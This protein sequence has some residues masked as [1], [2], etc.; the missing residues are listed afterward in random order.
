MTKKIL[1][2][3]GMALLFRHFYATSFRNQFM[4]NE[5]NIPTNG[6][7]GVIRHSLKLIETLH[8]T[9]VV[10]TWDMGRETIRNEWFKDYKSNREAPP[11]EMLPQFDYVK[12]IIHDM[13]IY[14]LGISGYEADDIIGT[15]STMNQDSEMTIVSGDRD[16]LQLLNQNNR[17][18]LTKKGYTEYHHY[19]EDRFKEEYGI[20]PM[21]FIDVKALM[22][23]TSDGYPGVKGI[24]EKTA[25]KL[26]K[27]HNSIDQLL[28][29][30]DVLTPSIRK[31]IESDL[32]SLHISRKLAEIITDAPVPVNE[33]E[34]NSLFRPDISHL[35]QVFES[36]DL[37]ISRKYLHTLH[38]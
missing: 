8:P 9:H 29:E 34:T 3:D 11:E 24:G 6:I 32:D 38:L 10:M 23:D 19:T 28:T 35:D 21:Q 20:S 22:G 26:I 13:G 36:H 33:Y 37:K 12:E 14:Q 7:Q 1:V 27:T 17:I 4:Y 15:L 5:K 25:L 18:W 16:L 30:T 2:I 31:K